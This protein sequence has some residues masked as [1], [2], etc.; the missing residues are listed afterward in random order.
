MPKSLC[1][2]G[3]LLEV[4]PGHVITICGKTKE[5]AEYF[6]FFFGSDNGTSDDFGDIQFHVGVNF[7][8]SREIVRNSY[9]KHIGWDSNEERLENLLPNNTGINPVNRG[10]EFK[11]TI[12]ADTTMFYLSIDEKPFCTY[13][14]RKPLSEIRRMNIFGDVEQIFQVNHSGSQQSINDAVKGSTFTGS[15][16]TVKAEMAL[17]FT[18]VPRQSDNGHFVLGLSEGKTGKFLLQIISKFQTGEVIA[19]SEDESLG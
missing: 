9:T 1:Y 19:A 5:S 6:D 11:F 2:S 15:I 17:V 12:Y 4:K 3:K 8:G 13:E 10:D 16:P 14:Y 7:A 18:G